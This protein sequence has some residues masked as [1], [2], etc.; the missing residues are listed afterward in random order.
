MEVVMVVVVK[1]LMVV[2]EEVVEGLCVFVFSSVQPTKVSVLT[3][4]FV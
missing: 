4:F 3:R 1:V 2:K